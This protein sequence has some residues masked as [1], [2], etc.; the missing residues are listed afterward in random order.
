M[1][2]QNG[3]NMTNN[4]DFMSEQPEPASKT[5]DGLSVLLQRLKLTAKVFLRADFCGDWAVDTSGE[6]HMP[7]HLI[8]RGTGWL[9]QSLAR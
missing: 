9:H 7:F 5:G 6:R 3:I 8:T 2:D 4:A 1:P